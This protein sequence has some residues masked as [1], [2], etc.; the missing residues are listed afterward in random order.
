MGIMIKKN[1]LL[2]RYKGLNKIYND[3]QSSVLKG[4]AGKP[5]TL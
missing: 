3:Y 4:D 2:F 5:S 1:P